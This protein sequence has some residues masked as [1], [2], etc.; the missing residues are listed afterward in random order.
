APVKKKPAAA[1]STTASSSSAAA[2]PAKKKAAPVEEEAV[3]FKFTDESAEEWVTANV[4]G[5]NLADLGDSNWKVRLAAMQAFLELVKTQPPETYEAEAI[6]R[7]LGKTPGWK[8]SN[9]QV[10]SS[11]IGILDAV[12]K[13]PS[14]HRGAAS[15]VLN[16]LTE[17]LGDMKVKKVASDCLT[18][19]A[20]NT[21]LEFVLSQ[22][23][24]PL[25]KA[26]SPKLLSDALIWMHQSV[27]EFG[28][29]GVKVRELVDFVKFALGNTNQAVRNSGIVVLG[30]LRM[31]V[32]PDIKAFV[33]DCNPQLLAL[34]DAEFDK[35]AA[36]APPAPTK[37]TKT[38]NEAAGDPT[39]DLF[40][41]VDITTQLTNELMDV[42]ELVGALK[43]R[44]VDSNKNLA[45]Y[46]VE[47]CGVLATAVGPPFEK[48]ARILLPSM[49][50][51]LA[52]QKVH[53]R[54]AALNALESVYKET[55][56]DP[57]IP[58]AGQSLV[59]DQPQMRKDLLKFLGDKLVLEREKN[60]PLPDMSP[61]VQPI[62]LCLQD[63]NSDVRKGAAVVLGFVADDVG[64]DTIRERAGDL[65]KGSALASLT[66]FFDAVKSSASGSAKGNSASSLPA[67]GTPS[68]LKRA[69]IA[70][71]ISESSGGVGGASGSRPK[72][73]IAVP[74]SKL[75][76]PTSVSTA[77]TGKKD[78]PAEE[79]ADVPSVTVLSSDLRAKDMR[80]SQDRGLTKWTFESPRKDLIDFLAEQCVGNLSDVVI[81]LMF[82]TDHYK[83]KD[84]AAALV[85]L[86]DGITHAMSSDDTETKVRY[87]ANSD[88][89]L[90][91]LTI[92]FFDTN[93]IILIKSLE[94]LEHLFRLIDD[95]GAFLTEYEA[96]AFLPFFINKYLGRISE[97]DKSLLEEKLKR[98]PVQA[99]PAPRSPQTKNTTWVSKT[100]TE[101]DNE[102]I[103]PQVSAPA[104]MPALAGMVGAPAEMAH[105]PPASG[106][107]GGGVRKE[108]SL[109]LDGLKSGGM[110]TFG[111]PLNSASSEPALASPLRGSLESVTSSNMTGS[112][113]SLMMDYV[114]A[115]ITSSDAYESIEA[116]KHFEKSLAQSTVGVIPHLDEIVSAITLQIRI[117][118][119]AAD[120]NSPG[121]TRL[122]KHL[123]G[124]LME[125]FSKPAAVTALSRDPVQ[126]CIEEL[127]SRLQDPNLQ[128][129]ESGVHLS[130]SMNVLVVR[131]LE[132]CDKNMIF[133]ILLSLL[134]ES[135][136]ST[137]V[138]PADELDAHVKYTQLVMKCLWRMTKIIGKLI[139]E[140]KLDVSKL[141]LSVHQFLKVTPPNV[142]KR[143]AAEKVIPEA[144]M[145]LKTVK[146][147]VHEI[148]HAIGER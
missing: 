52:D 21:S 71:P 65:Y 92:R 106:T 57:F 61:L 62:F 112:A 60:S 20:E 125:L 41:R 67:P 120:V 114:L 80:A 118:F 146:T 113:N 10:A 29:K 88:L 129:M 148:A 87:V 134:E 100:A 85:Q 115:Q 25:R 99:P 143:R 140:N 110:Q 56:V 63:K 14:F 31:F 16:G 97:K 124:A 58:T 90:K 48:N 18:T 53:I 131:I 84:Y 36:G 109:D 141:I 55:G 91:Y 42:S 144:D 68:K 39:D 11:M 76:R 96:A 44:L 123:V 47:I 34:I 4:Q 79:S 49:A 127:L 77:G 19:F 15:V 3:K 73:L 98:I 2:A 86:V 38:A 74:G 12:A 5:F 103:K 24:E 72:S 145:P 37:V 69:T 40:P 28:V 142:W 147:I 27:M 22:M 107:F 50:A 93:T 111:K 33:A 101:P 82:S 9:F 128:S 66:P 104:F 51:L 30:G 133:S 139:E 6:L 132:N 45:M 17:K 122:C 136:N 54:T 94:L 116:L 105:D 75:R 81:G 78:I 83:E 46:A 121:T 108:F 35:V 43:A 130:K 138:A 26:K 70:G 135:A 59:S 8:E 32:G 1:S 64:L 13:V 117:A 137:V 102:A 126:R 7:Y 95:Q 89:I 119:T 23:Y